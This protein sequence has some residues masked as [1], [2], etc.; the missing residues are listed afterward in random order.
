DSQGNFSLTLSP[1]RINGEILTADATDTAG[2]TSP[3]TSAA[4]PDI[5]PPQTPVILSVIDDVQA[6]TGPVAQ[7][8][9]TNDRAPTLNGTGE[10]GSTI[11]IYNGS[12]ALGTVVV[13]SSGQWSFTPPTPLTD[14]TWVL[15]AKA[16]DPAGNPSGISNAWTINVDG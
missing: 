4:A 5:T 8:G 7:N 10:A 1:P 13:P 15:T 14:G 11:T 16:T 2:N 9:L 3:T 12:D 6:T